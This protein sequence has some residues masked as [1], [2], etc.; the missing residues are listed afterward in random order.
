MACT[1]HG[2]LDRCLKDHGGGS[3][4]QN[5]TRQLAVQPQQPQIA[6]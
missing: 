1:F 6:A 5:S 2:N 4:E 3:L